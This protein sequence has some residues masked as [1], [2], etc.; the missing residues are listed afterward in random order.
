MLHSAP[1]PFRLRH[2]RARSLLTMRDVERL[3]GI[4]CSTLCMIEHG[5]RRPQTVTLRKLLSLYATHTQAVERMEQVW[6]NEV[7]A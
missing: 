1:S 7:P 4:S 5:R 3:T 2:M 6:G